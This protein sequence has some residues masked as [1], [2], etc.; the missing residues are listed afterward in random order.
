MRRGAIPPQPSRNAAGALGKPGYGILWVPY[1]RFYPLGVG[2]FY[3]LC[4]D[5][6]PLTIAIGLS[7]RVNRVGMKIASDRADAFSDYEPYSNGP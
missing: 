2:G 5:A 3:T 1:V 6:I 7:A 4:F